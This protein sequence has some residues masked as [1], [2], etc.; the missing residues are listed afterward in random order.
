MH[1]EITPPSSICLFT[2]HEV[3][4]KLKGKR[5]LGAFIN[6]LIDH[7]TQQ[8]SHLQYI[9]VTD[10]FLLEMNRKYLSHDT[11]TDIITFD[12]SEKKSPLIE[13]EI[14]ISTERVTD[15]AKQENVNYL[16]E[17]YR[18]IIHGALHLCGFK[19]KTKSQKAVMR[20]VETE[21]LEKYLTLQKEMSNKI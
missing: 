9:F 20:I 8:E 16:H 18:V 3:K 14:Y 4:S 2:D 10:A 6:Q 21:W 11:Y 19:D 7:Y 15:N 13:A 1:K 12:L 17:L 5:K